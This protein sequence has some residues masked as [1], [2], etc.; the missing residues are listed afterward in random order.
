MVFIIIG[1]YFIHTIKNYNENDEGYLKNK[2]IRKASE[3]IN[4]PF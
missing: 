1:L 2:K 4:T 3:E